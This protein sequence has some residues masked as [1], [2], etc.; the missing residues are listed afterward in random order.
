MAFNYT[1]AQ[2]ADIMQGSLHGITD[3]PLQISF[4]L[5]DSRRISFPRTAVFFALKSKKNDGHKYI[6]ELIEK[7]VS[8]FVVSSLP[9][10]KTLLTRGIFILTEN[11]SEALHVLAAAHR[12]TFTYPVTGITGSNGKTI[13]KEWLSMLLAPQLRIVKNPR[14]YNSQ[15]GVPLSVWNMD[16]D[17]QLGIFEAGIS[18]AGEME[19]LQRI[20]FPQ[21]GIFTNIG[22]AHDEG[23]PD[24]EIK[25]FEKLKLFSNSETL[26]FCSH[27]TTV[28]GCISQWAKN[29]PHVKL[30]SWGYQNNDDVKI[31]S[32]QILKDDSHLEIEFNKRVYSFSI[33]FTD[34]ASLENLM[35]CLTFIFVHDLYQPELAGRVTKL[36]HLPMRMEMKQAI[37][38]CLLINDSYSS[39]ILSLGIALDFL[40]SQVSR[41]QKVVILSDIQQS[42]LKATDLYRQVAALLK[43]KGAEILIAIGKEIARHHESFE[44]LDAM[45]FDDTRSFLKKFDFGKLHNMGVLLKGARE[46]EFEHISRKLQ[47]LDHEHCWKLTWMHWCIILIFTDRCWSHQPGLW[48]WLRHFRMAAGVTKL[49]VYS[50]FT[51]LI[52]WPLLLPMK[53]TICEM[54]VSPCPL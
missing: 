41:K 46:F 22:P 53:D 33:P 42:G 26:V 32:L 13:V 38:N 3:V 11:T 30:T 4:L 34:H 39:D 50:S 48:A 31:L 15:I 8:C 12:S 27:H 37:N 43:E 10:N 17:H 35:H 5:T 21:W 36:E 14:S 49:P 29:H 2:L 28:A 16:E 51:G 6:G 52:T 9:R 54:P 47:L 20:I 40:S 24:I 7:G 1:P 25:V 45:F 44:Q 19:N 18:R 23:F